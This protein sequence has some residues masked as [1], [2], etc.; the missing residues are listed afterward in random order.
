[1]LSVP[2]IQFLTG[3][4]AQ[5][6]IQDLEGDRPLQ[7]V[8]AT[9]FCKGSYLSVPHILNY[10]KA[11][12]CWFHE[13]K[14]SAPLPNAIY[15]GDSSDS[16]TLEQALFRTKKNIRTALS[17]HIKTTTPH[18]KREKLMRHYRYSLTAARRSEL[19]RLYNSRIS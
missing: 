2:C 15:Q 5:V 14:P 11:E 13:N 16:L 4:S 19:E 18:L 17:K 8:E 1:M 6:V 7:A 10:L 9:L 12:G 3:F